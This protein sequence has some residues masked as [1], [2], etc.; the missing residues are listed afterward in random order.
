MGGYR[1]GILLIFARIDKI[2][3]FFRP[4]YWIID[5][6][7][8]DC[9]KVFFISDNDVIIPPLPHFMTGRFPDFIY[10]AGGYRGEIL[11]NGGN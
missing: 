3:C 8:V 1:S 7:T 10:F 5:N 2:F 6:I 4:I 9:M 11:H